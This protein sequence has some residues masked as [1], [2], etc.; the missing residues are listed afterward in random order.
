MTGKNNSFLISKKFSPIWIIAV[1]AVIIC[2]ILGSG[3]TA[4]CRPANITGMVSAEVIPLT[5]CVSGNNITAYVDSDYRGTLENIATLEILID[6]RILSPEDAIQPVPHG[7]DQKEITFPG[8]AEGEEGV[9]HL[10]LRAHYTDG[11]TATVWNGTLL[12]I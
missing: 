12:L 9:I 6:G 10:K 1:T 2:I 5:C 4:V 8:V 7:I 3:G 11:S